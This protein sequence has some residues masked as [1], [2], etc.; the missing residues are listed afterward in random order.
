MNQ[1]VMMD[2]CN[3]H[4]SFG[5]TQALSGVNFTLRKGEIH[6]VAGEN[7]AGKS[8]LMK[9]I[10]GI[11]QP[12]SGT[13]HV[14]GKPVVIKGPLQAQDLGIGFV[15]QEIVLCPDVSV[16]ENINMA[17]INRSQKWFVDFGALK[18]TAKKCLEPI[19]PHIDPGQRLDSLSISEQQLVEIAKALSLKCNILILDEPTAA[20]TET[21]SEALFAIMQSLKQQG[22]SIIYISHRMAEIFGQCDRVTVLRDGQ[23]VSTDAVSETSPDEVVRRMVGREISHLYP[24]KFFGDP[25]NLE[26]LLEVRQLTDENRFQEINFKLH[27]GKILG[28]AGL[29]GAGRSEMVKAICGLHP[30]TMGKFLLK[31][32]EVRISD[33]QDSI[34]CGVAYLSEDRKET[35]VFLDLSIAGNVSVLKLGQVS[36]RW[37]VI[38]KTSEQ[39]QASRLTEQLRLK[40]AGMDKPVSSLSGGN[41]QKVAIA[42]ILSINPSIIIMDEPTRGIDVGA[43]VEIHQLIRRLAN[44]GVGVIVISSELPEVVGLCDRV[45]VMHQGQ[46]QGTLSGADITEENIIQLA[47]GLTT[48]TGLEI[49]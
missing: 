37:G 28:V 20:L 13:I 7:G 32:E 18:V 38:S 47:S 24:E 27:K 21:E 6:A 36:N 49:A 29:M 48:T 45:M 35:G 9:I 1:D 30:K 16:A 33:Y 43:K 19:A 22:I 8:T 15:H 5:A 14:K 25:G 12:D 11:H 23:W 42:K 17:L 3:V 46:Q 40:S 31:G 4:K 26:V 41:Q 39:T 10:D 34:A 44:E 2:I